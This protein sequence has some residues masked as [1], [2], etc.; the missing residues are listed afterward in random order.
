MAVAV[1]QCSRAL[2][3]FGVVVEVRGQVTEVEC[4]NRTRFSE[5]ASVLD[6]VHPC[7]PQWACLDAMAGQTDSVHW[8]P[9]WAWG[10]EH[11]P[12]AMGQ[13]LLPRLGGASRTRRD[14]SG[15]MK[16]AVARSPETPPA[17]HAAREGSLVV[18]H[19]ACCEVVATANRAGGERRQSAHCSVFTPQKRA[20]NA[21]SCRQS[22][23]DQ[24]RGGRCLLFR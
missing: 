12:W 16:K 19:R 22:E 21:I 13:C 23:I 8:Q 20:K 7:V 11:G 14:A 17:A 18:G 15:L 24:L 5:D 9:A 3:V 1:L 6:G 4:A 2:A 10:V